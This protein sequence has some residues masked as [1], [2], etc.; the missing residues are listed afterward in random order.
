MRGILGVEGSKERENLAFVKKT[1]GSGEEKNGE[2]EKGDKFPFE[3]GGIE[4][5]EL[6]VDHGTKDH[7][8]EFGAFFEAHEIGGDEGIGG[9][10]EAEDKSEEHHADAAFDGI[11][12]EAFPEVVGGVD[13]GGF[14]DGG[15]GDADREVKTDVH[16]V[17][18]GGI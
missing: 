4:K 6:G 12:G 2:D 10:T 7:E 17:A 9:G 16:E 1:K 11:I 13:E 15:E 3:D 8:G 5:D 18:E 14:E